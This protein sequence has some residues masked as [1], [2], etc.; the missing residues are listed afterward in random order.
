[1]IAVAVLHSFLKTLSKVKSACAQPKVGIRYI[2]CDTMAGED[3]VN[4]AA[5]S[6][7][8]LRRVSISLGQ[9]RETGTRNSGWCSLRS[10][11]EQCGN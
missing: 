3:D 11:V 4:E 10:L 6:C 2:S 8:C 5:K 9:N 7:I 1:M